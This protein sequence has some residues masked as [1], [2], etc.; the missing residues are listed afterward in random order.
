MIFGKRSYNKVKEKF[1]TLAAFA[2]A[3]SKL[4]SEEIALLKYKAEKLGLDRQDYEILIKKAENGNHFN[5]FIPIE[6]EDKVNQLNEMIELALVDGDFNNDE[7][8]YFLDTGSKLGYSLGE[9]E[10]IV[11]K[12]FKLSIPKVFYD[13]H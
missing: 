6:T 7:W 5:T 3:D 13:R 12:S 1:L 2:F 8:E 11:K 9:L 10:H 4:K